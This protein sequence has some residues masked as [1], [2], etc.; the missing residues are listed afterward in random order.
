LFGKISLKVEVLR[1]ALLGSDRLYARFF[2]LHK[3]VASC[4]EAGKPMYAILPAVEAETFR[5]YLNCIDNPVCVWIGTMLEVCSIG[6]GFL[7]Q[8]RHR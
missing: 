4:P 5:N 6:Y 3:L 8:D 2:A 1:R 7:L